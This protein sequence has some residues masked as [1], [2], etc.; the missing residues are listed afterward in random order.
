MNNN[1]FVDSPS[2]WDNRYLEKTDYWSLNSPNPVFVQLLDDEKFIHKNNLLVLGSGLGHDAKAAAQKGFN[3]TGI[4]FS[5]RAIFYSRELCRDVI[6][7]PKFI[8]MNIF[9]LKSS[10]LTFDCIYEYITICSFP[11]DHLIGFLSN[12]D[13]VLEKGGLFVTVLFPLKE[14]GA[15]P[16]Y[17]I[18]IQKFNDCAHKFWKLKYYQKN[19]KSVKPR[20]NNEV[21]LI[22]SKE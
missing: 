12:A 19:V 4:D 3:V 10:R 14:V 11:P 17:R 21:L 13:A 8:R 1:Y 5:D 9:E 15:N 20:K 6:K 18:D 16:P 2:Y 7:P 22:Y